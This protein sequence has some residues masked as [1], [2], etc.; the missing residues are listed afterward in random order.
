MEIKRLDKC[1]CGAIGISTMNDDG[2]TETVFATEQWL[3]DNL[4]YILNDNEIKNEGDV[5]IHCDHCINNYGLDL[6][7]CGSGESP[8]GCEGGFSECGNPYQTLGVTMP[9]GGW[10][11]G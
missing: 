3:K 1:K 8:T 7:A 11:Y 10:K 2:Q 6:C 5:F 4:P 9:R